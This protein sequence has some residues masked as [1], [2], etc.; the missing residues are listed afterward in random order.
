MMGMYVRKKGFYYILGVLAIVVLASM[1][2]LRLLDS[3]A[4]LSVAVAVLRLPRSSLLEF[5]S[6]RAFDACA[7]S[8][9]YVLLA[10]IAAIPS[11]SC[12]YEELASR[13]YMGVEQRMGKYRYAYSRMLFAGVSGGALSAAGLGAYALAV[14]CIFPLNPIY[15]GSQGAYGD[16]SMT[17]ASL[18]LSLGL[19]ILYMASYG[20][21]MSMFATFLVFL[22]PDLY[23]CLGAL[24]ILGY[25]L[26]DAAMA[27]AML[28]PW[29]MAAAL[30]AA[31]G[32]L[33]RVK[34]GRA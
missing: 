21:A 6:E 27:G 9:M 1:G 13:F 15:A 34:G 4:S 23:T 28:L 11:A 31:C 10:V 2:S 12:I 19:K 26:K 14:S 20:M 17:A 33:W 3:D 25:L 24:F 8:W 16:G 7:T 5:S 18:L 29:G 32:I 22:Y 30:A